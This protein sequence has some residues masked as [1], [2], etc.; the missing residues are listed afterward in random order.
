MKTH[1]TYP[2]LLHVPMTLVSH[3]EEPSVRLLSFTA[4]ETGYCIS[5][6]FQ[7]LL[8]Q[9]T[10]SDIDDLHNIILLLSKWEIWIQFQLNHA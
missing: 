6:P 3:L 7:L 4:W 5:S 1:C 2:V 9:S 10:D 8:V